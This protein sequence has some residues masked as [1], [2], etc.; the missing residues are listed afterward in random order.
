MWRQ[1]G[2][3][4]PYFAL[5]LG[6]IMLRVGQR[7][8]AWAAYERAAR[9]ADRFWPDPALQQFLRQLC[10]KRQREIEATLKQ[11]EVTELRPRFESE[12]AYGESYQRAYQEYEERKIA[13]GAAITDEHFFEEFHNERGPIAS[14]AG[15]EEWYAYN[16]RPFEEGIRRLEWGVFGAGLV[17]VVTAL[18]LR[19]RTSRH[20]KRA[21]PITAAQAKAPAAQ[22]PG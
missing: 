17:A 22:P 14:A 8:I 20:M 9:M 1:G 4:N 11:D 7:Y 5:A 21:V 19:R 2:G 6:E 3:A 10:A 18:V 12:L 13:A 16:P 15:P